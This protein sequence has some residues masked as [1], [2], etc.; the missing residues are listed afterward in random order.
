MRNFT[1][2]VIPKS[3][4]GRI[5]LA[6]ASQV[7]LDI[8]QM[9]S[10]IGEYLIRREMAI[11]N[12]L[13]SETLSRFV[14]YMD[15]DG[16]VSFGTSTSDDGSSRLMDD[17]IDLMERT[18][19]AMGSGTGGYWME[20][21]YADPFYRNHIIY[22]IVALSEHVNGYPDCTLSYGNPENLKTFGRADVERLGSFIKNKGMSVN[23]LVI[24]YISSTSSKSK[25]QIIGFTYGTNKVKLQFRERA[26]ENTAR[27]LVGKAVYVSGK[28]M[29][30][31]DGDLLEIRDVNTVAKAEAIKFRRIIGTDSDAA[32]KEPAPVSISYDG[33]WTLRNDDLGI[34]VTKDTWDDAVQSFH[35]YFMFL[36]GE[37]LVEGKELS[38]EEIQIRDLLATMV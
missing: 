35:E 25:G 19:D 9:L 11:Q 1:V 14:L 31:Q 34:S 21:N 29:Y 24:G 4:N 12:T 32:L 22:D 10:D 6:L 2:N 5:P 38:D 3:E 17:T 15:N 23:G 27:G 16:G 20:D 7:M 26:V 30:S 36:C 33:R 8:Q 28:L 13:R 37:Y 18:M